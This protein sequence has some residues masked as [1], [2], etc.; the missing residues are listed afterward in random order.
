L[1]LKGL[2]IST[3]QHRNAAHGIRH[4][5][6]K[7]GDL[8]QMKKFINIMLALALTIGVASIT[9]AQDSTTTTKK[10]AKKSKTKKSTDST[11]TTKAPKAKGKSKKGTTSTTK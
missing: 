1:V 6:K 10:S 2:F 5:A 9:V 11:D 3:C 8:T 7:E 4:S